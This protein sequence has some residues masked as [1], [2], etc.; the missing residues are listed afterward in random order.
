V[1]YKATKG[2]ARVVN[3]YRVGVLSGRDLFAIDGAMQ[4]GD[5]RDYG[6]HNRISFHRKVLELQV[7]KLEWIYEIS[8]VYLFSL[9]SDCEVGK[10]FDA[11]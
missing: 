10:V 2:S 11:L 8:L 4:F 5:C 3:N 7:D 1:S 6:K 9:G